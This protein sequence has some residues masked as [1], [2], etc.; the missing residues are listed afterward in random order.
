MGMVASISIFGEGVDLAEYRQIRGCAV[1]QPF[2]ENIK[3][4]WAQPRHEPTLTV[5]KIILYSLVLI[6]S[7]CVWSKQLSF[8]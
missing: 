7:F 8:I 1:S 5:A 2:L 6:I 3:E 4:G